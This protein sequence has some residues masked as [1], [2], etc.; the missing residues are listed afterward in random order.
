MAGEF[1][2]SSLID[3]N[4]RGRRQVADAFFFIVLKGSVSAGTVSVLRAVP[5]AAW[6][7]D[8]QVRDQP[9]LMRA[10][11][12]AG[13]TRISAACTFVLVHAVFRS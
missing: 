7:G 2:G 3:E 5:A 11:A 6:T 4:G 9:A 13:P 1:R 8:V 10:E 12:D